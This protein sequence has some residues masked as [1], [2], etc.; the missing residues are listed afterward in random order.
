MSWNAKAQLTESVLN[1]HIAK[2]IHTS[3]MKTYATLQPPNKQ[4]I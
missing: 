2:V 4:M 1:P 3:D